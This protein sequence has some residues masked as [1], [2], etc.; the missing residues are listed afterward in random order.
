VL[1]I[2][3]MLFRQTFFQPHGFFFCDSLIDRFWV[4]AYE[5]FLPA[6]VTPERSHLWE[7]HCLRAA[8]LFLSPPPACCNFKLVGNG[9]W[10]LTGF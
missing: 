3:L 2:A 6:T 4:V 5:E 1:L 10:Q 7:A 9:F 8:P